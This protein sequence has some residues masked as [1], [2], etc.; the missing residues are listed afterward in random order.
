MQDLP[1][2]RFP[3]RGIFCAEGNGFL[4]LPHKTGNAFHRGLHQSLVAPEGRRFG[5][6]RFRGCIMMILAYAHFMPPQA[7]RSGSDPGTPEPPRPTPGKFSVRTFTPRLLNALLWLVFCSMA[8]TGLLLAFRLPPG[9]QGGRGLSAWGLS[10]HEWGDLHTWLSYGFLALILTHLALHWR[11]F[12]QVAA[13]K[14]RWPLLLGFGAGLALLLALTLQ[15]VKEGGKHQGQEAPQGKG[16]H[17][18]SRS[19]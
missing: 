5:F 1:Q 14:K 8:G 2:H 11:W 12:W 4:G 9:S 3:K 15:P 16:N 7:N 19:K 17:S 13:R 6:G 10:R 18:G